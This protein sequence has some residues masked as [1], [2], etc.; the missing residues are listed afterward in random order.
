MQVKLYLYNGEGLSQLHGR[1]K[2]RNTSYDARLFKVKTVRTKSIDLGFP[3]ELWTNR[4]LTQ[5]LRINAL[6]GYSIPQLVTGLII[7]LIVNN[8]FCR[9]PM[10]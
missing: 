10:Q 8:T 1:G 9:F 4:S 6:E 2:P 5:Y 7:F 3:H